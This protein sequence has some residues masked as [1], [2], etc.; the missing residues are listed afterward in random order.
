MGD[1]D[2]DSDADLIWRNR[3]NGANRYWE[4][5]GT[6]RLRSLAA[7]TV[8]LTWSVVGSGDFDGDGRDDLLWLCDVS[9]YGLTTYRSRLQRVTNGS[10]P[11]KGLALRRQEAGQI[12]WTTGGRIR[13]YLLVFIS[14]SHD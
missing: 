3:T 12:L 7:R 1:F 9:P 11:F 6:V 4:V 8:A 5:V 10:S 2:A 14:L 13:R